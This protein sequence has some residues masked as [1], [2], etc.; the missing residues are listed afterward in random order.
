MR[1]ML[2]GAMLIWAIPAV[3]QEREY[4][5]ARPGLGTPACTIAPGRVSVETGLANWTLERD[6]DTR[7]DTVLIGDTQ[8]RI[9]VTDSIEAQIGWTPYGHVRVRD[10][11]RGD[12]DRAGRV[13]DAYLGI[14]ANLMNPDGKGFSAAVQPFVTVP[15]GRGPVG[16]G[17]WGAGAIVPVSYDLNDTVSLQLSPEIDAAV[18]EDGD[19][20]HLAFGTVVG[21]G[22]ALSDAV[23]G[24][25]EFQALRDNDP[26]D[27]ATQALAGLSVGWKVM[28]DL[29]LDAGGNAG[30]N[31]ASPDLE[32]YFGISR[33]F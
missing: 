12:I 14:K 19:G 13:G 11:A 4:C 25:L 17:D 3:A 32:L 21:L 20:R 28:D 30:L 26:A 27:H 6:S 5:P 29:Q 9:G 33:Q 7:T 23:N 18:D 10:K 1:M 16:A 15:V 2:A 31:A 24:T 22:V 8:L